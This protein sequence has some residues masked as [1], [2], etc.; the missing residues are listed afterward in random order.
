MG[1]LTERLWE[2]PWCSVC[3]RCFL[4]GGAW[5]DCKCR[6]SI[7]AVCFCGGKHCTAGLG[8]TARVAAVRCA[9]NSVSDRK[10]LSLFVC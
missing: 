6:A 5:G 9:Q 10:G 3:D 7:A 8:G 1:Q 2:V 4:L